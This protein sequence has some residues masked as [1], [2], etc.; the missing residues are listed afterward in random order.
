M[1]EKWPVALVLGVLLVVGMVHVGA[2]RPGQDWGGDFAMY[3]AHARNLAEGRP[4]A[5]TGYVY[6]PDYATVGPPAWFTGP[7]SRP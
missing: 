5:E 3:V 2:L 1:S 4:Y 7:T 6:N